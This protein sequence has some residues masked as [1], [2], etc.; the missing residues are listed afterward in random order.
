MGYRL[1]RRFFSI[2]SGILILSII[3]SLIS[4]V[5]VSAS[6]D[7]ATPE[8]Q[9][10]SA[11]YYRTLRKCIGTG[12]RMYGDIVL[13]ASEGGVANP[14][15]W[16]TGGHGYIFKEGKKDCKDIIGPAL[17]LWGWGNNDAGYSDFL[18]DMGYAY[19]PGNVR[20]HGSADGGTRQ[21]TFDSIV[22]AKYYNQNFSGNPV[23]SGEAR[24]EMFV[25]AFNIACVA[26][27]LGQLSSIDNEDYNAW[28]DSSTLD[29]GTRVTASVAGIDGYS[30]QSDVYFSK[31]AIAEMDAETG[32]Y[33]KVQ[34]GFVYRASETI[35]NNAWNK[36]SGSTSRLPDAT[37]GNVKL[38]G[39]EGDTVDRTCH[40]IQKGISENVDAWVAW[41]DSNGGIEV[42]GTV[43][44]AP[45]DPSDISF[46]GIEG[47]GWIICPVLTFTGT[48]ADSSF[49]FLASNF[50]STDTSLV[51]TGG[52][53]QTAWGL[54]RNIAN[55]AFVIAFLVIIFSQLTGVA[56]SNYG[57]KKLLPRIVIA[58]ILVN[59]SFTICQLAVDLS[60]ILG[61]SLKAVFDSLP[62]LTQTAD[63]VVGVENATGNG[64]GWAAI[65]GIVI[66]AG[67]GILLGVTAP[68]LLASVL[69]ILLIALILFA[70][71]ALIVLLI[72][73]APLAFV[74]F[75]LPNTEQW[76]KKWLKLFS[77]LLLLFPIIA[78]VFGASSLAAYIIKDGSDDPMV[79][80]IAIGVATVPFFV[81]P[82]LLKGALDGAGAIGAK[83]S[84]LSSKATGRVG[85]KAKETSR[86]AAYGDAMKRNASVR[87]AQ[88]TGGVYKGRNPLS[89]LSSGLSGR[90]NAG[91]ITGAAGNRVATQAAALA[92]KI[93]IENVEAARAQIDQA[94][95][96]KEDLRIIAS[97]GRVRGI[98][99]K[100]ASM[101]AAAI[102]QAFETGDFEG[103][104]ESWDHMLTE[105]HKPTMRSVSQA[106]ARS[107]SK[108]AFI[109]VGDL[110]QVGL[111]NASYVDDRTGATNNLDLQSVATR[112]TNAGAYSPSGVANASNDEL[113]YVLD[114]VFG[115]AAPA[116]LHAAAAEALANPE[117]SQ[118]ISKNRG[119]IGR[120]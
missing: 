22:Q 105:G 33:K 87:R 93:D 1:G 80:V 71:K 111:G 109:G 5:F 73:I 107:K 119:V 85:Q 42:P 97:G 77:S 2:S 32:S 82:L 9:A 74:A 117:I 69:A 98:N 118:H 50:L 26:K 28:L 106:I 88:I 113:I 13:T 100:D 112:G 70:R 3:F 54:M 81:V 62:G 14:S 20:W 45:I 79:Q 76:F 86:L 16:F 60:N 92:N 23:Q 103:F 115:G 49:D 27:D 99:G 108:P 56:V 12:N 120:M 18:E 6:I 43:D 91:R 78:V 17:E 24:Y 110:Q 4:P 102:T 46:C 58:A 89:R 15:K 30:G 63:S 47:I 59:L 7:T 96:T 34:H 72:V 61:Y 31:V 44:G 21:N 101:R 53:T 90:L 11:S 75:L 10:K 29:Q 37:L 19:E 39:F 25:N 65:I 104:E 66:A 38:Y 116:V 68:V 67:A 52:P 35:I 83:L 55:V 40:E 57:V 48:I 8:E 64:F 41:A 84:A 36:D 94:N 95:L 114:E 51:E